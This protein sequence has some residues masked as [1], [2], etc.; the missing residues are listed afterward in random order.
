MRRLLVGVVVL[1]LLLVAADRIGLVVAERAVAR[2]LAA[3]G[4]SGP[5]AAGPTADIRGWPFLTQAVRGRYDEV[6]VTAQ[7]VPAGELR[8]SEFEAT[9]R[10][11]QVPLSQALAGDVGDIPVAGLDARVVVPYEALARSS[12]LGDVRVEPAGDRVRVTG[13]AQVLGRSL[14]AAAVSRVDLDGSDILVTAETLDV[15]N[16]AVSSLLTRALQGR[17]DLRL[18]VRGLPYGLEPDALEIAP[19]GVVVDASARD[20]VLRAP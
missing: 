20:T 19:R 11:L 17:L 2:E 10:G 5:G 14:S 4:L 3:S 16:D 12:D 15:G 9:L 6:V 13:T 18:P 7:D 8:F 1:L